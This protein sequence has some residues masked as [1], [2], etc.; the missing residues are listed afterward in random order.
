MH[1]ANNILYFAV[2]INK[3]NMDLEL[4]ERANKDK[5]LIGILAND[6]AKSHYTIKRWL[7]TDNDN[8]PPAAYEKIVKWFK[9]K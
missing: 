6:F 9:N 5:V 2:S 3:Q 7:N 8:L 1:N 4:L